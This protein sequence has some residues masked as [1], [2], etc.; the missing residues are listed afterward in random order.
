MV[1]KSAINL[2]IMM[3][4]TQNL[5]QILTTLFFQLEESFDI[6]LTIFGLNEELLNY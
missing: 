2:K 5:H 6:N 1:Y 4:D 3:L